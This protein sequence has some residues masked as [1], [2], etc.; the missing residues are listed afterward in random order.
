MPGKEQMET[1]VSQSSSYDEPISDYV[2]VRTGDTI[3][4]AGQVALDEETG[5]IVAPGD[6]AKQAEK[7]FDNI[8]A[9]LARENASLSDV[10]KLVTYFSIPLDQEVAEEYWEVRKRAFGSHKPASTGV[11][12]VSLIHPDLVVEVEAIA[13]VKAAG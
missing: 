7:I 13:V 6:L 11:Q 3:Y 10:V 12:V 4:L 9:V 1:D 2:R 8:R 5:E